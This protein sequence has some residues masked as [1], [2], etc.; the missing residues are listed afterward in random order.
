MSSVLAFTAWWTFVI[1]NP[2][3]MITIALVWIG[4][5]AACT[6]LF[7]MLVRKLAAQR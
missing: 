5:F 6:Q 4:V 7:W 2:W 1:P 3:R